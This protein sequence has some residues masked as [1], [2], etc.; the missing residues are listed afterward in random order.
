MTR[1]D[2]KQAAQILGVHYKTIEDYVKQ[3]RENILT[4]TGLFKAP[5]GRISFEE[6]AFRVWARQNFGIES[7]GE[8]EPD[9]IDAEVMPEAPE[10][11]E[12]PE[13]TALERIELPVTDRDFFLEVMKAK[14]FTKDLAG[15]FLIP[16]KLF[17]TLKEASLLTGLTQAHLKQYSELIGG[18]RLIR[19]KRLEK[20]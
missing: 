5:N 10:A 2:K 19:K 9:A 14:I 13:Q 20:I 7:A 6:N 17:L 1:I 12:A 8:I 11:P 16:H 3:D 4:Q 18:R 15:N